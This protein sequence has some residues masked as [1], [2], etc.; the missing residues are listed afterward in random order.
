MLRGITKALRSLPIWLEYRVVA[1]LLAK[2]NRGQANKVDLILA[3]NSSNTINNNSLNNQSFGF[4]KRSL[5]ISK[6]NVNFQAFPSWDKWSCSSTIIFLSP[7]F[8]EES[9]ALSG[10]ANTIFPKSTSFSIGRS[11]HSEKLPRGRSLQP[12]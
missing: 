4:L 7:I 5:I 3:A 12:G 11:S 10:P 1:R 6:M 9:K 8:N 2:D